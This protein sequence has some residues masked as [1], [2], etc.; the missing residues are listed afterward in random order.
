[1]VWLLVSDMLSLSLSLSLSCACAGMH[2]FAADDDDEPMDTAVVSSTRRSLRSAFEVEN[3]TASDDSFSE[4]PHLAKPLPSQ[5]R[6]VEFAGLSPA[7]ACSQRLCQLRVCS[8]GESP[9]P[10]SDAMDCG[11]EDYVG[12]ESMA[13][14]APGGD[15]ISF[16]S[17]GN[18]LLELGSC[19]KNVNV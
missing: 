16:D 8:D 15:L 7:V 10:K 3:I 5:E 18:C 6:L 14:S 17:P 12:S 13:T 19:P 9:R 1:M 4:K 11:L 2:S